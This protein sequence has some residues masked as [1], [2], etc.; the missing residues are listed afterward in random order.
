MLHF[1][2]LGTALSSEAELSFPSWSSSAADPDSWSAPRLAQIPGPPEA[3]FHIEKHIFSI[4]LLCIFVGF[5]IGEE[6][7]LAADWVTAWKPLRE[8]RAGS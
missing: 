8:S 3:K 6:A 7:A 4:S 1:P 2:S 5:S